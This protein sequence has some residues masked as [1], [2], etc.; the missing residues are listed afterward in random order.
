MIDDLRQLAQNIEVLYVEDDDD[1][2]DS[3][4]RILQRFMNNLRIAKNGKEGLELFEQ[5]SEYIKLVIT[6]ISMPIMNGLEM[7]KQIKKTD[8]KVHAV[9][10]SAHND[11]TNLIKAIETGVEH[12]LIKPIE[13]E[14]MLQTFQKVLQKIADEVKLRSFEQKQLNERLWNAVD[15][16]YEELLQNIALPAAVVNSEDYILHYNEKFCSCIEDIENEDF[17]DALQNNCLN[18]QKLFKEDAI[19]E[20]GILDW[21]EEALHLYNGLL[22]EVDFLCADDKKNYALSI[23]RSTANSKNYVIIFY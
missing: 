1:A 9:V 23:R 8:P 6:D 2:R 3:T 12:F 20:N 19:Y 14:K 16:G 10:I 7:L 5:R 22:D 17:M 15:I 21:K 11:T 18:I 4:T 13:P